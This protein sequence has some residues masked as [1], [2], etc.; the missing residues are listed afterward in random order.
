MDSLTANPDDSDLH[1]AYGTV[2]AKG[3]RFAEALVA[4]ELSAGGDWY[5]QSGLP[6]H[7]TALAH[8]GRSPEAV[9]LRTSFELAGGRPAGA[10]LGVRLSQVQDHLDGG[11]PELAVALAEAAVDEFPGSPLSFAALSEARTA[12]GDLDG[13]GWALLRGEALGAAGSRYLRLA[14]M[15]WL[16]GVGDYPAAW[17]ISEAFRVRLPNDTRLWADRMRIQRLWGYPEDG[18]RIALLDRFAW[19]QDPRFVLEAARC[20]RAAGEPDLARTM[21]DALLPHH[22]A[23]PEV[24]ALAAELGRGEA[25]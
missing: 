22:G 15:R 14:R 21:V 9:A 11:R 25:R 18:L 16:V 19:G 1:A 8:V 12:A 13:A 3:G 23:H 20:A 7:A 24:A 2:L 6:A 10:S 4:F 5:E 17:E